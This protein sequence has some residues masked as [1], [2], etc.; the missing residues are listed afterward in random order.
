MSGCCLQKNQ[1][2]EGEE[3]RSE[4]EKMRRG[5]EERRGEGRGRERE[6]GEGERVHTEV[7]HAAIAIWPETE[8]L[9]ERA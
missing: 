5:R 4:K 8:C 9:N 2:A 6:Q 1:H 3:K 7:V